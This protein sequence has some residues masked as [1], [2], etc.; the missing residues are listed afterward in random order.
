V[1][2]AGITDANKVKEAAEVQRGLCNEIVIDHVLR[3][4]NYA[5]GKQ[6]NSRNGIRKVDL[7]V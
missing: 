1:L 5:S 4:A 6:I 2:T 7:A 3:G